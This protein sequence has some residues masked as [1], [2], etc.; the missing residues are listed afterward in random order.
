AYVQIR[1]QL[2]QPF[3][4][5]TSETAMT[6]LSFVVSERVESQRDV[7]SHRCGIISCR[8]ILGDRE[9]QGRATSRRF[10]KFVFDRSSGGDVSYDQSASCENTAKLWHYSCRSGRNRGGISRRN[11]RRMSLKSAS[12]AR[13]MSPPMS[14]TTIATVMPFR[15]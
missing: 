12:V 9:I 1:F 5:Q 11:A 4:K 7:E 3:Q 15:L 8:D 6:S 14:W 10:S 2:I 13:S